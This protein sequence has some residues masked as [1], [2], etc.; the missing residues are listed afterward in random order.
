MQIDDE[1]LHAV[2]ANAELVLSMARERLGQ[3][4]G[5]DEPGVR[6]LDGYVQRQH[7]AGDPNLREA[8][9]S[10]LG[11]F[12]GK[13]VIE[14]YGGYWTR[15]DGAVG[16]A[17]DAKNCVYPFA[18]IEKHLEN[19]CEDTVH[20]FFTMIP[21]VFEKVLGKTAREE[22]KADAAQIG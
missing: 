4:I 17:F 21:I 16:V 15:F 7:E 22:A 13:C 12:L 3:D 20:G 5:F 11:S 6:W 1:T 14:T 9:V 19:G 8:L 2:E 18:K 10:R